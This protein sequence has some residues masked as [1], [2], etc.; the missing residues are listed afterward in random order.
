V[1][2]S[3]LSRLVV[4]CSLFSRGKFRAVLEFA[5]VALRALAA[6]VIIVAE[7]SPMLLLV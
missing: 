6:E 4:Q 5:A 3:K 1:L 7:I 2:A